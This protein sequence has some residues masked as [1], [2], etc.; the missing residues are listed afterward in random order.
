V[1]VVVLV[2]AALYTIPNFFPEVPAVQVS[3]NKSNVKI[4]SAT[5]KLVDDALKA[6]NIPHRDISLDANGLKVRFDDADLQL[7]G[8]DVIAKKLNPDPNNAAYIVALNLLSSS[9]Q[10]LTA[11]GALPMYLGL[12]L[13]GG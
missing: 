5:S 1:I 10:W 11:I 4:D 9:P 12:D 8:K 13:R 6:A 3:T 7:K 2:V